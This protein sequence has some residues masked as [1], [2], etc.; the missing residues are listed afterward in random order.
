MTVDV[1]PHP[2]DDVGGAIILLSILVGAMYVLWTRVVRPGGRIVRGLVHLADALDE[3]RPHVDG[4]GE[5]LTAVKEIQAAAEELLPN[6]GESIYDRVRTILDQS[7]ANAQTIQSNSERLSRVELGFSEL[8]RD[9]ESWHI[10][11]PTREDE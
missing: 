9:I 8:R 2:L 4:L 5:L 11:T 10:G 1:L 6:G 7:T 3:I